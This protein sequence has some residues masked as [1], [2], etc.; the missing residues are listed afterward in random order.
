MKD[1]NLKLRAIYL[2]FLLVAIG[3]IL[4]YNVIRWLLDIQLDVLPLR[5]DLLDF[6]L[7][8]TLPWIPVLV[9]LRPRIRI[10]DI[11]G[12]Y[13]NGLFGYQF[14]MVGAIAIPL[15]ISQHY[16]TMAS[17]Q[18]I[19]VN[20]A[21]E[22][23]KFPKEKYFKIASFEVDKNA[24]LPH[25]NTRTSGKN[26]NKLNFYLYLTCPF[27][28]APNVWYGIDYQ[29]KIPNNSTE[30][31]K[32][33]EY[34]RFLNECDTA[35]AKYDVQNVTYFERLSYISDDKNG[36]LKAIKKAKPLLNEKAT[37]ILSPQTSVFE[38]RLGTT[39]P[40]LFKSFIIGM[41]VILLMVF[42][43]KIDKEELESFVAKQPPP[44]DDLKDF[45]TFFDP[46]GA[47]PA[48]TTLLL[49]HL[50]VF[51]IMVLYGMNIMSPTAQE[52]LE[53]GGNRRG[54]VLQGQYW[55]LVTALFIHSGLS[56]LIMNLLVL[57]IAGAF[58]EELI[59]EF[60]L[61]ASF[62]ISGLVASIC[63]IVWYE[64]T[65]SVGASGAIAGWCGLILI[66]TIFKIYPE[67]LRQ[68]TKPFLG[69]VIGTT[70]VFG[71]FDNIDHAA[72]LGGLISGCI[73]GL[74]LI[75]LQRKELT[76]RSHQKEAAHDPFSS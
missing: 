44:K 43:P 2:P 30:T 68:F 51:V 29:K 59:G 33:D 39:L 5:A 31:F 75:V 9:W 14:A 57:G 58:L 48:T 23:S 1:L 32:E 46:R 74:I 71:F 21:Q 18:L 35:F 26:D 45:L 76:E 66:F 19:E 65:V 10:L 22:T 55:R 56:H 27:E 8:F 7:P 15:L 38:E 53:L 17:F 73:I 24:A 13:D 54:E 64:H 20:K 25:I 63:S 16:I 69:F 11:R 50:A 70:V 47:T 42:I 37:I 62:L 4:C 34:K 72:H 36:F 49:L 67:I 6:W 40:W 61:V 3:T 28:N 60:K 41:L 52:L 12:K